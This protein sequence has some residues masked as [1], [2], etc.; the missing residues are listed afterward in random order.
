MRSKVLFAAVAWLI[1]STH[2]QV[3]ELGNAFNPDAAKLLMEQGIDRLVFIKRKTLDGNHYYTEYVNSSWLPGGNI[4]VLDLKTGAVREVVPELNGGVFNRFDVSYDAKKIVFDYKKS[5][6]TGYR[7]Y[8]VN[9]DGTDLHQL[10]FDAAD[11]ARLVELYGSKNYHHGT[12]DMHPCYLPDGGVAFVSTRVQ[13]GIL[14]NKPDAFTTKVMYRMEA[15]GSNL[16]KLSNNVVSEAAPVMMPDGRI[17]YHRWEYN[18]KASGNAKCLWAMHPNGTGSVEIYGNTLTQPDTLIYGRSVPGRANKFLALVSSHTGPNNAIGS[19]V[20]IDTEK[21]IRTREPLSYITKDVDAPDHKGFSFLVDGEW[22]EDDTGIPGRLFKDPY[23]VSDKLFIVSHKPKGFKWNDPNAYD[24]YLLNAD[25]ETMPL[26]QTSEISCWHPLPLV[27][28]EKPSTAAPSLDPRLAA[29]NMAECIVADVYVGMPGVERGTIK[30]LRIMEQVGRPWAARTR[31][32]GDVEGSA[33]TAV[34]SGHVGIKVQWGVVPVEEDG[35]AYFKVPAVRNI[36]F[37]ALDEN[38]M[39]VQTERTF[40]NYMPGERRSC[41]GCHET[42]DM[43][44]APAAAFASPLALRRA[45]SEAQPQ[46]GDDRPEKV[47]DYMTQVQPVWNKHC[48]SCHSGDKPKGGLD[49]SDEIT[50][51]FVTSY[52]NLMST[53]S[54]GKNALVGEYQST[55]EVATSDISYR[56]SYHSGSHTAPLVSVLSNGR[57]TPRFP[58]VENIAPKLAKAHKDVKLS[59]AEFVAVVNWIDSFGQFYPS[60]WGLKNIGYKDQAFFRPEVTFEETLSAEVPKRFKKLFE[61]PPTGIKTVPRPQA[62]KKKKKKS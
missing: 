17:L 60:Y 35:S 10:T 1:Y 51:M 31:W 28:R 55:R 45:P 38:H 50:R 46:P 22:V 47:I 14:C 37:Q 21:N 4:C 32:Q 34:G 5:K 15:D 26:F 52:E 42:P 41:I 24:L 59:Q 57:V 20:M 58:D 8:E 61:D 48:V 25:G 6:K 27:A 62:A 29:E 2:A 9:V 7:I 36:Y 18:D 3:P 43:A 11:E 39:M 30:Y 12:D 19:V 49:L 53:K 13:Q 54:K 44:P 16:R 33:H 40:I 23:P 56:E